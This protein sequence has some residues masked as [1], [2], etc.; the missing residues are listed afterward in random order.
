MGKIF[1]CLHHYQFHHPTLSPLGATQQSIAQKV[2]ANRV[3]MSNV[4]YMTINL[5][6]VKCKSC[7]S[8][9]SFMELSA[10]STSDQKVR[11]FHTQI[12]FLSLLPPHPSGREK[13]P[14]WKSP[15]TLRNQVNVFLT[16]KQNTNL[17]LMFYASLTKPNIARVAMY[18]LKKNIS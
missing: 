4:F 15:C 13:F 17:L 5:H 11:F 7:F 9:F 2:L 10:Y 3:I 16:E 6:L 18:K 12:P 8:F 1:Q 14:Q